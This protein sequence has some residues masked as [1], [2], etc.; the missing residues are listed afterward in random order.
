M[1]APH[2][3]TVRLPERGE[4]VAL[5][6]LLR[7][8]REHGLLSRDIAAVDLRIDDRLVVKL[9]PSAALAREAAIAALKK[10]AGKKPGK[11]I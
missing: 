7:L 1:S 10:A 9:T 8:D 11:S 4:D 3:V 6:E 2:S 5:A